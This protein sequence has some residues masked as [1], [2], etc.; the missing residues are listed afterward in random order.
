MNT[1]KE[2]ILLVENDPEISDLIS[3]QTLKPMGYDVKVVKTASSALE[4]ASGFAPDVILADLKLPGLSGKDLLVALSAEG[5]DV[6]V[7][8]IAGQGMESDI[9]HAFRLGAIDYISWPIREAEVLSSVER[10]LR[11]VR[12]RREKEILARQ[13]NQANKELQRRVR[14][15]T[16]I[17]AIGKAVISASDQ[18]TI[19]HK[20]MEGATYITESDAGW[21]LVREERGKAFVLRAFRNVPAEI[22]SQINKAW[23][24]GLSSLVALSGEPL[25]IHA[26]A[27]K[28]F[29]VSQLGGS[30]LVAPVKAKKEVIGLLVVVRKSGHPYGLSQQALLEAVADYASISLVNARLFKALEERVNQLQ[31]AARTATVDEQIKEQVLQN[32]VREIEQPL[33]SIQGKVEALISKDMG[34]LNDEQSAALDLMREKLDHVLDICRV[35][36]IKT[37]LMDKSKGDIINLNKAIVGAVERL[38]TVAN[39]AGITIKTELPSTPLMAVANE[40]QIE[41]VLDGLLSNAIK[42]SFQEGKVI[43]RGERANETTVRVEVQDKGVGIDPKYLPL[44]FNKSGQT[45]ETAAEHFGGVGIGLPLINEIITENGGKIWVESQPGQGSAF[46]FTLKA[47]SEE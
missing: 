26:D 6:P 13:L 10:V 20:I 41:K 31:T 47:Y 14:E 3:Q 9:I 36:Q 1:N 29:K 44:L 35:V 5:L 30:A 43:L 32:A 19:F 33:N 45:G 25:S 23:D 27:L 16:T 24:D 11:Q 17:F 7:I 42:Y 37:G 46:F 12:S 28:R 22:S 18:Q 21:L 39:H 4:E 2:R 40:S 8:V 38:Q 34:R 15:L